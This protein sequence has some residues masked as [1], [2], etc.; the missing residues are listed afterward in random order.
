MNLNIANL[1]VD[2][3]SMTFEYP[4]MPEFKVELA[5]VAKTRLAEIRKNCLKTSYDTSLGIP[6]QELDQEKWTSDFCAEIIKGW[7]GFTVGHLAT[8][9]LIDEEGLD[10]AEEVPFNLENAV[11]LLNRSTAFDGW[12]NSRISDLNN[13]RK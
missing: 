5:Y 7:S 12:V 8:L 4:G 3:R 1:I 6:T 9:L 2:S 13:F 10:L 11:T